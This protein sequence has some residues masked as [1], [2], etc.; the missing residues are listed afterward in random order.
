MLRVAV[1][2]AL[3][4]VAACATLPESAQ[5]NARVAAQPTLEAALVRLLHSFDFR[6]I[7]VSTLA[8]FGPFARY[9]RPGR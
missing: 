9:T 2:A 1:V 8:T 6:Y 5:L 7:F 4:G 3:L